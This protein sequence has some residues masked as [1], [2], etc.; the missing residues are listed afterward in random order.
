MH[1]MA[2]GLVSTIWSMSEALFKVGVSGPYSAPSKALVSSVVGGPLV[3]VI[4]S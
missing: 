3:L 2:L 4:E 1:P